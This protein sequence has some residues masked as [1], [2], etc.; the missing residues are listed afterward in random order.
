MVKTSIPMVNLQAQNLP[1]REEIDAAIQRVIDSTLFING[2]EVRKFEEELQSYLGIKHVIGCANGT[3]ALQIAFMSLGLEEGD[4]V[5]TPSFTYA[6]TAEILGLLKLTPVF[7]DVVDT[8]YNIDIKKLEKSITAKTKAVLPVH[9]F[10]GVSNMESILAIAEKYGLYVIEDNAQ[11]IGAEYIFSDGRVAKTG[12]IGTMGTLSFFPSKNLGCFGDGGAV[13]TNDDKLAAKVRIIAKHGQSKKYHHEVL[14]CNS[15][16]DTVQAAIL[17]VKLNYLDKYNAH[18]RG[19]AQNYLNLLADHD[20]LILPRNPGY[21]NHVYHQFT[22]R[23]RGNRD[24]LQRYLAE[25]GIS[26]TVYYP[27]PLHMQK[28]FM[29]IQNRKGDLTQTEIIMNEVISLPIDSEITLDQQE[30]ICTTLKNYTE[31]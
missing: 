23:Y 10:G 25:N 15:R 9:L 3:D 21:S 27:V 19:A 12:T 2:P 4:E 17:S 29:N 28:A 11:G 31:K 14:G 20:K 1:I 8:D 6:A 26:S 13:I 16:L 5:I 22:I 30:Y 7:V 24:G 18:R